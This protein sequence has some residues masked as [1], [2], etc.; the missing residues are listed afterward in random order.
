MSDRDWRGQLNSEFD[1]LCRNDVYVHHA[2]ALVEAGMCTTE[3]ALKA[4]VVALCKARKEHEE[5][6]IEGLTE[7]AV[8][9]F[10]DLRRGP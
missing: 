4:C 8:G 5:A 7:T 1:T 9:P 6:T 3:E 10:G 2:M